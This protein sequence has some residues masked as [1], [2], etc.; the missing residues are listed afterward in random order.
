M[1]IANSHLETIA[2]SLS[3]Q[4]C[5]F[6]QAND[7]ASAAKAKVAQVV[8]MESLKDLGFTILGFIFVLILVTWR[9]A[10][11]PE[12]PNWDSLSLRIFF[13]LYTLLSIVLLFITILFTIRGN[14]PV[15]YNIWGFRK[16]VL[17]KLKK[18]TE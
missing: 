1:A 13:L 14:V 6:E 3:E 17:K 10:S 8:R 16:R 11:L 12:T 5:S 9:L 15:K 4:G 18:F 2:K 7:I